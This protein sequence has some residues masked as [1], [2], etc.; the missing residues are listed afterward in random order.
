MQK[1]VD[2]AIVG[3]GIAGLTAALYTKRANLNVCVIDRYAFGGK[4][5]KLGEI[6]NYPGFE[7]ISGPELA[8][9]LTE[10]ATKN[11][12]ELIY[13]NVVSV[14]K[15][16]NLF[17]VQTEEQTIHAKAVIIATGTIEKQ[18]GIP[19]EKEFLNRG[20]SYCGTCDG[21]I[22]RNKDVAVIGHLDTALDEASYLAGIVKTLYLVFS[23]DKE[24]ADEDKLKK[25][26]S[27]GNVVLYEKTAAKTI[28]GTDRVEKLTIENLLTNEEKDLSVNAVFP[29]VGQKTLTEFLSNFNLETKNGYLVV[30]QDMETNVAGLYA[31]GDTNSK[32]LRQLVTAAS[33][34][35]IAATAAIRYVKV[36]LRNK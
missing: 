27:H 4:L 11:E 28:S 12:I 16:E 3:G 24:K 10:Q 29:Y 34:G 6:E 5:A 7:G 25:L 9:K 14:S 20:V 23:V 30:N 1:E 22:Y 31:A 35:S 18:L 36:T 13:G 33:D 15:K 21:P 2:V 32:K 8:Y 19:G 26:L 17:F